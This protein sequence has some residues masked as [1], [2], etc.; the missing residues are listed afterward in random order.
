MAIDKNKILR[1]EY[2]EKDFSSKR[3]AIGFAVCT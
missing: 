3:V 1:R 2:V